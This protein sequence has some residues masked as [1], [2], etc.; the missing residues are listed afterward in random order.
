MF[1]PKAV[2]SQSNPKRRQRAGSDDSVKPP[3]AKRHRSALRQGSA[4][5]RSDADGEFQLDSALDE[6]NQ[7]TGDKT[8]AGKQIAIRGPKKH[9]QR[10]DGFDGAVVLVRG[11]LLVIFYMDKA[12]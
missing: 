4:E 11:P 2:G 6:S 5:A 3:K 12:C 1:V 8:G 9:E 7:I 10:D